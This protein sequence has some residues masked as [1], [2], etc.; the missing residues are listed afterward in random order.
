MIDPAPSWSLGFAHESWSL[1]KGEAFPIA[2]T[3]DGEPAVNVQRHCGQ[4]Q[5]RARADAR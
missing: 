4:Q 5:A 1:S 3:F 2:L